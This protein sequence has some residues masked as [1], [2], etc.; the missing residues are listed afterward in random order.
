MGH[1]RS[2][3]D[4]LLQRDHHSWQAT[5]LILAQRRRPLPIVL[6]WHFHNSL[7]SGA[8]RV[9]SENVP[10]PQESREKLKWRA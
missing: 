4:I 7:R 10:S 3:S 8:N 6:C 2:P 5:R 9:L 1:R